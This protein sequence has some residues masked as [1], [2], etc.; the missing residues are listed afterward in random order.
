MYFNLSQAS[1][2][3]FERASQLRLQRGIAAISSAKLLWALFEEDECRAA[4]WLHEAGLSLG[5]FGV[6]FGIMMLESPISAPSFPMGSYGITAGQYVPPDPPSQAID[7]SRTGNNSPLV[8]NPYSDIQP[9]DESE[10]EHHDE[11]KQPEDT[12]EQIE[13][14]KYSFYSRR[15]QSRK[16][17]QNRLQFYLDEQR[18]NVGLL[19]PEL[20]DALE[21]VA[22]RFIRS[23]HRQP[24]TVSGG[25][26]PIAIGTLTFALTTEHLLLAAV[27]DTGDVGRWLQDNGFEAAELYQRIDALTDGRL[28]TADETADC[29]RTESVALPLSAACRQPSPSLYRLLDAAAN[30]GREAMRV[31]EDYIRFILDDADL[32]QR[33]KTFRHQFKE[34]LQQFPI[35]YRLEARNTEYDVGTEISAE[36]EYVRP[37]V[38]D[39]L[40]ANLSRLQ[41]SLRSLEEFSK[42][43]DAQAAKQFEQLRYVGYTLHKEVGQAVE[44]ASDCSTLSSETISVTS[45]ITPSSLLPAAVC[46][47][48]SILSVARL[49]ALVDTCADETTFTQFVTAII[50]G[51]VDIIQLRDKQ[52]DDRT[53]LARSRILKKCIAASERE[54]LFI[55]NDRPDLAVLTGADGVHVGQEELPATLVRQM[56]GTLLMGV[57]THSIEQAKQA[58]LDGAD[59][60]GVGPV[61]ESTTKEFSQLAGLEYLREVA[62]EITIPAFAIGGITEEHL[63]EVL[64]TNIRRVAVSSP[65]LHAENP[66]ETAKR[67]KDKLQKE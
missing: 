23:D 40:S 10:H 8:G 54:V 44:N 22:Q 67:W 57:S 15:S 45:A 25:I 36:G 20:E 58:V 19:T 34:V 26:K 30:R 31:I 37:S 32:T 38:G 65:L 43:F 16:S 60:I 64:Q 39:L 5:K 7:A 3:V 47:L 46:R 41:E 17:A 28:H 33:L 12:W 13:P 50:E 53:L 62:A 61:F 49:Y 24:M 1:H 42:M 9:P 51:G 52:A 63:D 27:L 6:E 35:Q 59:Y 2:R 18:I 55:M 21:M 56:V 14:P 11:K 48:P 29:N 66:K 4:Q